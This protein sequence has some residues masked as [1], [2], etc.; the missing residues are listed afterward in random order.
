MC[1]VTLLGK[2]LGPLE[3]CVT[4]EPPPPPGHLCDLVFPLVSALQEEPVVSVPSG[5]NQRQAGS[6][7]AGSSHA[8]LQ[9]PQLYSTLLH[10]TIH[11]CF[12]PLPLLQLLG[13]FLLME[14]IEDKSPQL[15]IEI[16]LHSKS[17]NLDTK[18]MS[19]LLVTY[20]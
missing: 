4:L 3:L 9:T 11:N 18:G 16:G 1:G 5:C 15:Q 19:Y 6:Q 7:A 12:N 14:Y 8:E 2:P 20:Y 13:E 17:K 10:S